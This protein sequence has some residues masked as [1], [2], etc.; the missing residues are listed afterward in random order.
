MYW[1]HPNGTVDDSWFSDFMSNYKIYRDTSHFF[2]D[3]LNAIRFRIEQDNGRLVNMLGSPIMILPNWLMALFFG[4]CIG[5]SLYSCARIARVWERNA[6][7]FAVLSGLFVYALPWRDFMFTRMFA[8]NYVPTTAYLLWCYL[9]FYLKPKR[10]L[11]IMLSVGLLCGILHEITGAVMLCGVV[12]L[13]IMSYHYRTHG[14]IALCTG[15]CIGLAWLCIVPGTGVRISKI[16]ILANAITIDRSLAYAFPCFLLILSVVLISFLKQDIRRR[17]LTP[18]TLSLCGAT[19][20]GLLIWQVFNV[21]IRMLYA[22]N[23]LAITGLHMHQNIILQIQR[24]ALHSCNN[25]D[26]NHCT[27]RSLPLLVCQNEQ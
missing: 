10:N 9:Y 3:T 21:G 2:T 8:L 6:V 26:C 22:P 1:L 16:D 15:L 23:M 4:L 11:W 24:H 20:V 7:L 27:I 17:V 14:F 18:L 25:L 5:W 19:I 12:V 13:A